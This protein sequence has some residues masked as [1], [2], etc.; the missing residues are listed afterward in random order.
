VHFKTPHLAFG[1]QDFVILS[2][3]ANDGVVYVLA[4]HVFIPMMSRKKST[5]S[6]G[7]VRGYW[8]PDAGLQFM[9]SAKHRWP[10][11]TNWR[12]VK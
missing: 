3:S 2:A 4:G 5:V 10:Y 6:S 7:P 12:R 1:I 11:S 9:P 8:L